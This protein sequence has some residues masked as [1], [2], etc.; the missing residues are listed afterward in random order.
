MHGVSKFTFLEVPF[1]EMFRDDVHDVG[2]K[3]AHFQ[4]V[5]TNC[6]QERLLLCMSF[7]IFKHGRYMVPQK[8]VVEPKIAKSFLLFYLKET[9]FYNSI[10]YG[11]KTKST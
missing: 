1:D 11:Y 6:D 2:Y 8:V 4:H 10:K 9:K 3:S 7:A 5:V